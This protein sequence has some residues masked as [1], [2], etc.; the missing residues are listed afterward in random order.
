MYNVGLGIVNTVTTNGNNDGSRNGGMEGQRRRGSS[1]EAGA[2]HT[3]CLTY[4]V[5]KLQ[6]TSVIDGFLRTYV[7]SFVT[8]SFYITLKYNTNLDLL[9][10]YIYICEFFFFF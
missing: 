3:S 7:L 8:C 1:R 2:H 9:T 4:C 6:S 5:D 10:L